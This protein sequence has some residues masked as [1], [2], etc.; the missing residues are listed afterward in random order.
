MTRPRLTCCLSPRLSSAARKGGEGNL[1]PDRGADGAASCQ[2]PV[3]RVPEPA[4]HPQRQ[5][6]LTEEVGS[7]TRTR[8]YSSY[9]QSFFARQLPPPPYQNKGIRY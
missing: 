8:L 2:Q 4:G 5:G 9:S 7:H 1:I 3:P 6:F